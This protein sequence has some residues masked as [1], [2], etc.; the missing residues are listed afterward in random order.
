VCDGLGA[1]TP[2]GDE[3]F[4]HGLLHQVLQVQNT[5]RGW[6]RMTYTATWNGCSGSGPTLILGRC[7]NPDIERCETAVQHELLEQ[8]V[9]DMLSLTAKPEGVGDAGFQWH[10]VLLRT[11]VMPCS[12]HGARS[13]WM[14]A[15]YEM[16]GR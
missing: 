12:C 11:S 3:L 10:R 16:A 2:A 4:A 1:Y 5:L 7:P 13:A 15:S 14:R 8:R 9:H 6:K